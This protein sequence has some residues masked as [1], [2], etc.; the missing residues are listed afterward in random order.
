MFGVEVREIPDL[1]TIDSSSSFV[2]AHLFPGE[3][4]VFG[5]EDVFQLCST[6]T[7]LLCPR[8]ISMSHFTVRL[9]CGGWVHGSAPRFGSVLH[10]VTLA[11]IVVH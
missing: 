8:P 2:A 1:Q 6:G 5:T 11:G 3:R 10:V 9:R 4:Q 7:L